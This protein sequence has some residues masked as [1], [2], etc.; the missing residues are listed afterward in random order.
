MKL[1]IKQSVFSIGEKFEVRNEFNQV[2]YYVEGSF[3]SIPKNFTI[4]EA[5][6]SQV[7]FI[8]SQLFR[9]MGHYDIQTSNHQIT[10]KRVFT[11]FK[12]TYELLGT[13][14][15]LQGDI[16]AHEYRVIEG[17]SPIMSLSKHWFTWG[18]SYELDIRNDE[19]AVLCLAIVIAVDAEIRKDQSN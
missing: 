15:N 3:F 2:V 8:E 19:D 1:Y 9:W 14:W 16:W 13:S 12:P 5:N 6:G 4:Y 18:D 10:L 11:F 17:S 7:C